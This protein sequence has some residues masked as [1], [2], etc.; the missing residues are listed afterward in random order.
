ML[1]SGCDASGCVKK[2]EYL[3]KTIAL[4]N[5]QYAMVDVMQVGALK[6]RCNTRRV[7]YAQSAIA[8][9]KNQ[10]QRRHETA[11]GD[12]VQLC[13]MWSPHCGLHTIVK[14]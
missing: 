8:S 9:G 12:K 5:L 6:R 10:V 1:N 11:D 2:P 13:C 4:Y 14:L 3:H 7:Q